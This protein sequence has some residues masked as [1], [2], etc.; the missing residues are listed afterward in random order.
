MQFRSSLLL[1]GFASYALANFW[2]FSAEFVHHHFHGYHFFNCDEVNHVT[3]YNDPGDVSGNKKGVRV[4]G[5]NSDPEELEANVYAVHF[6]YY[7]D[8]GYKIYDLQGNEHG[9]CQ[10]VE[11]VT[12][13]CGYYYDQSMLHC[14][15]D[16]TADDINDPDNWGPP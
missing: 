10:R 14:N 11:G 7:K 3:Y 6:T 1:L 9:F 8:R 13:Q 12:F 16:Y 5:S 4:K 15:S 2:V